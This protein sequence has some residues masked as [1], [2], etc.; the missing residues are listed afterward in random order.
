MGN[1]CVKAEAIGFANGP[2]KEPLRPSVS[3]GS[4]VG[5]LK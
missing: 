3:K 4:A 5:I 2:T 1:R